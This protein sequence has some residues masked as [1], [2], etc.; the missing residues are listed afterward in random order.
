[1]L[2]L[3]CTMRSRFPLKSRTGSK[4]ALAALLVLPRLAVRIGK[5][6]THIACLLC[7]AAAYASFFVIRDPNWLIISTETQS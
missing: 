5:V 3:C 2:L 6:R 4:T 1:M 7:G